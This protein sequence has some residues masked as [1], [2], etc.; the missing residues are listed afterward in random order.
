MAAGLGA[1]PPRSSS[2]A[3]MDVIA[4]IM[5]FFWVLVESGF[6]G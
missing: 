6:P 1:T 4:V 3:R 2:A 5:V